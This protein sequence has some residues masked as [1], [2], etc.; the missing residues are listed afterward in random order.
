MEKSSKDSRTTNEVTA[1]DGGYGWVIVLAVFLQAAVIVNVLPFFDLL[2]G[3]KFKLF[4]SSDTEKSSVL[5]V[6]MTFTQATILLVDPLGEVTSRRAV[7]LLGAA[8]QVAG[9]VIAAVATSNLHMILG[10]GLLC[11]NGVGITMTNNIIVINQYFN[12][13]KAGKAL[14]LAAALMGVAGLVIPQILKVL[15]SVF[16]TRTV[17]LIYAALCAATT[18]PGAAL[19]RP[20]TIY[21]EVELQQERGADGKTSTAEKG[22]VFKKILTLIDWSLLKRP[23]FL[24]ILTANSVCMTVMLLQMSEVGLLA[25]ARQFSVAEKANLF[26]IIMTFDIFAK[27][28]QGLIIDLPPIKRLFQFPMKF[29]YRFNA[30]CMAVTMVGLALADTFIELSVLGCIVAFFNANIMI[31]FSQILR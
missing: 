27:I 25:D 19:V 14:G 30:A 23:H 22:N 3:P 15:I 28:A 21:S 8:S 29:L 20:V 18:L 13:Q 1:P 7:A 2:F 31:N 17:I 16:S 12:K 11:G 9:L 6:F 24:F 4:Q 26:T 5:A 10:F